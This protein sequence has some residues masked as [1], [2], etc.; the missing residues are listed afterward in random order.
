MNLGSRTFP[1]GGREQIPKSLAQEILL[2]L[3]HCIARQVFDKN[4][5][6][7]QF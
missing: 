2:D 7:R 6:F 5:A 1:R 4:H 3:A